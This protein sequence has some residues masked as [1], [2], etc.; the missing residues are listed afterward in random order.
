MKITERQAQ[1][2]FNQIGNK[3]LVM[4]GAKNKVYSTKEGAITFKIG[5]NAGKVTHIKI[6]LNAKD[7]YDI[8]FYRIYGGKS[9]V[10]KEYNDLYNNQIHSVI[11]NVTGMYLSL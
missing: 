2:I 10:L 8:K 5:R 11:E 6:Y 1:E 3:A 4:M 7:L 9:K